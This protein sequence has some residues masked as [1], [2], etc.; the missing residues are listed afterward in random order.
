[1][2]K[3]N[4]MV[5]I[6]GVLL[7]VAVFFIGMKVGAA[8]TSVNGG[9]RNV[10]FQGRNG[11]AGGRTGGNFLRGAGFVMG[12]VLSKDATGFTIKLPD[13]GSRIVFTATSTSVLKSTQGTLNDI[14]V[15]NTINVQGTTNTD[16]SI[17]A[18]SIIIK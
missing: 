16:G 17:T 8:H 2:K 14:T 10:Q 9:M 3:N 1:M 4:V 7:L 15:G 12:E 18:K 13:G 5:G 6:V 11:G